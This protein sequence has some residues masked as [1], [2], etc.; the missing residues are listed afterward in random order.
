[1]E[2]HRCDNSFGFSDGSC[3]CVIEKLTA[4]LRKSY[5]CLENY[6]G[7]AGQ[8]CQEPGIQTRWSAAEATIAELHEMMGVKE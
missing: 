2:D 5:E 7:I 1:M 3:Q 6:K 4:A 8:D